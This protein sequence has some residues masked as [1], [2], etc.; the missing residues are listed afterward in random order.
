VT[1]N[2]AQNVST[3]AQK[4]PAPATTNP[5]GTNY[6]R[7]AFE[8][9]VKQKEWAD[10]EAARAKRAAPYLSKDELLPSAAKAISAPTADTA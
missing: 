9:P 10:L 1:N 5:Q 7:P 8:D 4:S 2:T 6:Q 3:K